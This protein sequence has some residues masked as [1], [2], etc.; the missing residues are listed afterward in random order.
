MPKENG[1]WMNITN[2]PG[3]ADR[4]PIWSPKGDKIAWFSDEDRK[5][6]TLMISAQDGM[7]KP[8]RI[9]IGESKM[10]WSP[11][12]NLLFISLTVIEQLMLLMLSL[13]RNT[14]WVQTT[15]I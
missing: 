14:E 8:Q 1:T 2:S 13:L 6:Y 3:V 10:A 7:S 15:T 11:S 5:G 12:Q 4:N 9:S